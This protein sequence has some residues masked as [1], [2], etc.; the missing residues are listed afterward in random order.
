MPTAETPFLDIVP[1]RFG[2]APLVVGLTIV[3]FGTSAPEVAVSVGSAL[4]GST[5]VAIGNVV[6]SNVFNILGVLGFSSLIAPGSWR[7]V[8][9]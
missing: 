2:I 8:R 5:D 3:A 6:G 9:P 7:N 4:R 1:L